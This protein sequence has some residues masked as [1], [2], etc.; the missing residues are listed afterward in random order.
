MHSGDTDTLR[1]HK[2]A[3]VL[4]PCCIPEDTHSGRV[5]ETSD[6]PRTGERFWSKC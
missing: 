6:K 1:V 2:E 3:Y 5:E 4:P